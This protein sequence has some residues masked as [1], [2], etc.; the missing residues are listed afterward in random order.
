MRILVTGG[1]GFVGRHLIAELQQHG[2]EPI[3]FDV[4]LGADLQTLPGAV[5]GD[6]TDSATALGVVRDAAPDACIHLAAISFVPAGRANPDRMLSV[7]VRGTVNLLDA[8]K[9][10]APHSRLLVVST[11]QVYGPER[12]EAPIAESGPF[13]PL[14]MYAISKLAADQAALGYAQAF[15]LHVMTVRPNN[16]TGPGQRPPFVVPSFAEQLQAIRRGAASAEI[17][18]GN[19]ESRREF[20]DV[21]DVV[22][23]YRLLVEK[24][25]P[26][27]AYNVACGHRV[28]IEELLT[29]MCRR[30]GVSPE[31]TVDPGKYRPTD[32]TPLLDVSALRDVTGWEPSI[33]LEKTLDDL[34]AENTA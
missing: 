24:G 4:Q 18:V 30:A 16:H 34:L 17:K 7:N 2:H 15:G 23:A 28:S 10:D 27:R 31:V 29:L 20:M 14:S 9:E 32:A 6:L 33:P 11:S 12:H 22:R 25:E 3:P 26:A 13:C 19:L 8:V 1:N 5:S 21:R